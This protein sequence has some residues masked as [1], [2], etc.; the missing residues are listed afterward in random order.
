VGGKQAISNSHSSL[1]HQQ[2]NATSADSDMLGTSTFGV[3]EAS[4]CWKKK[5]VVERYWLQTDS[6]NYLSH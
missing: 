2:R 4:G 1:K 6:S 3:K 5:K